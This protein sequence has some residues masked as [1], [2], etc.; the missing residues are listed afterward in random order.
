MAQMN[1]W[2]LWATRLG[3]GGLARVVPP[4][5]H[6][7]AW[8]MFCSA[9]PAAPATEEDAHFLQSHAAHGVVEEQGHRVPVYV[10]HPPSE[11]R[12]RVLLLHGWGGRATHLLELGKRFMREGAEVVLFDGPGSG[13]TGERHTT[14]LHMLEVVE[15]LQRSHGP[16][17]VAVG[18]S[19]G[20]IAAAHAIEEGTLASC[21]VLVTVGSPNSF[22]EM[23]RR[24]LEE[25]WMPERMLRDFGTRV[26]RL[27]G[28]DFQSFGIANALTK[29]ARGRLAYLCVHDHGDKEVPLSDA[30][31][32]SRALPWVDYEATNGLGHNRIL[33]DVEVQKRIV[34]YAENHFYGL[35]VAE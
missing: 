14:L 34:A 35:E 18:H 15:Q 30:Q 19:F 4:L 2:M 25:L 27:T 3:L 21:R 17:D 16:F 33:R 28:R 6:R 5:A 23:T 10:L 12:M 32:I 20:G 9:P 11:T 1:S 31:E 22:E 8:R 26:K 29:L 7:L 13:L 24:L